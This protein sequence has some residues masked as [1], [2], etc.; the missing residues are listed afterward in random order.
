M[1]LEIE[2]KK[3]HFEWLRLFF[4]SIKKWKMKKNPM[5]KEN[6]YLIE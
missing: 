2:I 1:L 6:Y 4:D 5:E 3:T